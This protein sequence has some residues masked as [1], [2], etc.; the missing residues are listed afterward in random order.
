MLNLV[1]PFMKFNMLERKQ[2]YSTPLQYLHFSVSL[3]FY[4]HTCLGNVI[5]RARSLVIFSYTKTFVFHSKT[6]LFN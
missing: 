6:M 2:L 1:A 5:E 4:V 3:V